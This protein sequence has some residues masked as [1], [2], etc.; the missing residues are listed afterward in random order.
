MPAAC[1]VSDLA[2]VQ[3]DPHGCPG[4][5]HPGTGP[6]VIGSTDVNIENLPA[7]RQDDIG[8][9]A[10]CCGPNMWTAT[11]G[12]PHVNI[13]NKAAMRVGDETTHCGGRI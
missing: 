1:R 13:N 7:L 5:P 2:Q 10:A 12:A 3:Q 9:H 8:V 6:S 11:K 4:C